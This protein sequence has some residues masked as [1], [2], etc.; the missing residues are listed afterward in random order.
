MSVVFPIASS[1]NMP[2]LMQ[3][4]ERLLSQP[5]TTPKTPRTSTRNSSNVIATP[6]TNLSLLE[7]FSNFWTRLST[8]SSKAQSKTSSVTSSKKRAHSSAFGAEQSS[9][10]KELVNVNAHQS[11]QDDLVS[12]TKKRK[13]T[14]E[15][16]NESKPVLSTFSSEACATPSRGPS[17]SVVKV[18]TEERLDF[19][20]R[21]TESHRCSLINVCPTPPNYYRSLLA[22]Q[23]DLEKLSLTANFELKTC[24]IDEG[25]DC[26]LNNVVQLISIINHTLF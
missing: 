19:E 5:P 13:L 21:Y 14:D 25:F 6:K 24:T 15:L 4:S 20:V 10:Q 2:Y 23:H 11:R 12:P 26:A 3:Q 8:P 18:S 17:H 16:E 7:R 22:R 9:E 1:L